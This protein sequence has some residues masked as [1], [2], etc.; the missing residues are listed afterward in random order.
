MREP[1]N[2]SG[3]GAFATGW[4]PSGT[5]GHRLTILTGNYYIELTLPAV[6][7]KLRE[8]IGVQPGHD[9][10]R[11]CWYLNCGAR[12]DLIRLPPEVL[13]SKLHRPLHF[14]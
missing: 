5:A 7:R 10:E 9:L 6:R 12:A 14:P 11:G 13:R 1:L 4:W 8:A 3:S 2:C